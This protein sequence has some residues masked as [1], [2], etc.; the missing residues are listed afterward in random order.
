MAFAKHALILILVFGF[1]L[2]TQYSNAHG[3]EDKT[4]SPAPSDEKSSPPPSDEES[5]PPPSDE[6]SSPPSSEEESPPPSEEEKDDEEDSSPPPS[7]EEKDD[8]E[9]SSPPPS[10]EEKDDDDDDDD[11]DDEEESAPNPSPTLK[12]GST[13]DSP[14]SFNE[15]FELSLPEIGVQKVVNG[16]LTGGAKVSNKQLEGIEHKIVEFK[17]VLAKREGQPGSAESKKCLK[18]CQGNLDDAIDGVKKGIES[19]NK[20]DL[21]KANVDISGVATDIETCND[22]FVEAADEDKDINAFNLWIKGVTKECL[23]NLKQK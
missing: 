4:P 20:Q 12:S 19:I 10:E 15:L 3:D 7:E 23:G 14:L 5:S 13:A 1:L 11:D 22:C 18:Q 9:E 21:D 17:S 16:P 8:E 6:E 2:L